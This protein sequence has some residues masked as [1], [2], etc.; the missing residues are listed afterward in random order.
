LEAPDGVEPLV[1][2]TVLQTVPFH[3]GT[4]P[5]DWFTPPWIQA[6]SRQ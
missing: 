2:I 1:N 3:L 5:Y 6:P 4:A